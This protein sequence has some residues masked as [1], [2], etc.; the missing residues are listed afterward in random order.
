M[1]RKKTAEKKVDPIVK[2]GVVL[3]SGPSLKNHF[4]KQFNADIVVAVNYAITCDI[5]PT[6]YCFGDVEMIGRHLQKYPTATTVSGYRR[7]NPDVDWRSFER[8]M[9]ESPA[10]SMLAAIGFCASQGCT[11][12]DLYGVDHSGNVDALGNTVP[13]GNEARW[14]REANDLARWVDFY[15]KK[16]VVITRK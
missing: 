8:E 15:A 13:S 14:T 4:G 9:P 16:G 7:A 6:H 12:I 11:E 5:R 1:A 2:R 3:C 10:W